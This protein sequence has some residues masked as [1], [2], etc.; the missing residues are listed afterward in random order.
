[1][2]KDGD[3]TVL[4]DVVRADAF[5]RRIGIDYAMRNGLLTED[6]DARDSGPDD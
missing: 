4:I 6:R 5:A 3:V 1:L 2:A